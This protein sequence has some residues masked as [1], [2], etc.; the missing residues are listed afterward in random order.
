[1]TDDLLARATRALRNSTAPSTDGMEAMLTRV[2]RQRA[3]WLPARVLARAVI[4]AL[5]ATFVGMG[6]W[7]GATGRL[8]RWTRVFS[9]AVPE[10][11]PAPPSSAQLPSA[12][13]RHQSTSAAP[14]QARPSALP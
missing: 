1:M 6:A 8:P 12:H 13:K 9:I 5:A 10:H 3:F 4:F 11:T 2:D 14:G 7:A